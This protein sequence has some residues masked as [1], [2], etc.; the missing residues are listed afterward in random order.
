M[1]YEV[2][3][4]GRTRHV[5]VHRANGVFVV[6]VDGREWTVDAARIDGHTLSLLIE[7]S[8]H[9]VTIAP[10]RASGQLVVGV[11]TIPLA[12][13][14]NNR[15]RWGRKDDAAGS[16]GP[17]RLVSPM[18]GKVLRILV[19]PGDPVGL[20]QALVV[21]EAMKMENEIRASRE[22]TV[23]EVHVEEGQS[24]DA[25]TLLLVVAPV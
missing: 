25:G 17:E 6:A 3:I 4:N 12:V 15:R 21:I 13:A 16:A 8:S 2:E 20:K 5:H 9:E 18:P 11:G 19:G 14:L 24:V 7:S 1:Q 10:D 23:A 22:G